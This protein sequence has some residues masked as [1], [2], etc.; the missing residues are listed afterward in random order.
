MAALPKTLA[1]LWARVDVSSSCLAVWQTFFECRLTCIGWALGATIVFE[2]IGGVLLDL[3]EFP[4]APY[5]GTASNCWQFW[6]FI[7]SALAML[8]LTFLVV[9]YM[10]R[11]RRFVGMLGD[12]H[13]DWSPIDNGEC[14]D[15]RSPVQ[16]V[17]FGALLRI[18]AIAEA[19]E[20]V[21]NLLKYP[22]IVLLLMILSRHPILDWLEITWPL[23]AIWISLVALLSWVA[24][25]MRRDARGVRDKVLV[26]LRGVLSQSM[27]PKNTSENAARRMQIRL[28]ISEIEK[29]DGGA[30]RPLLRDPLVQGLALGSSG[31]LMLI[32]QLLPFF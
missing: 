22:V 16:P 5:R 27:N 20:K 10:E 25:A 9:V 4:Q 15:H 24:H 32:H 29:E 3:T 8:F 12:L 28:Y 6:V 23:V 2:V 17:D 18:R 13:A 1:E 31:G 19:T 21:G 30:F 14:A 7:L 26:E 11:C